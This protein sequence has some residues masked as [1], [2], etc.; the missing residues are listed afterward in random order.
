MPGN[1]RQAFWQC[2]KQSNFLFSIPGNIQNIVKS[3][4]SM[5]SEL[6]ISKHIAFYRVHRPDGFRNNGMQ[7]CALV[8]CLEASLLTFFGVRYV[9]PCFPMSISHTRWHIVYS[10]LREAHCVVYSLFIW[11]LHA[12]QLL[13]CNAAWSSAVPCRK[14]LPDCQTADAARNTFD[15]NTF[16]DINLNTIENFYFLIKFDVGK[17]LE[18]CRKWRDL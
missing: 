12:A 11:P 9:T 16:K 15:L 2:C 7:V 6:K 4:K 13:I 14:H 10:P 1:H 8:R 3:S 18:C 5:K 17:R